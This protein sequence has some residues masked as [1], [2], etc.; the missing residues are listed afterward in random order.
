MVSPGLT[1]PYASAGANTQE[2]S[3]TSG[4]A[5]LYLYENRSEKRLYVGV[6]DRLDRVWEPHNSDAEVLR[7]AP[8]SQILQT[9]EPFTSWEDA[10]KAEAVAIHVA[11][12]SGIAVFHA[13]DGLSLEDGQVK[14]T[15]RAGTVSTSVL[16]PAVKR[17]EGTVEYRDLRR[18][19]IVTIVAKDMND[20]PGPYGGLGGA[21]FSDRA[22]KWWKVA[23]EK[24]S[25][26][27]RLIA[28]L[29]ASRGVILG[30]WDVDASLSYGPDDNVFPF[31]DPTSDDPRGI[32]GM[33]LSGVRGQSGR[34]YS[35]D[36]RR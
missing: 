25:E 16:G 36:L 8:G 27:K 21:V 20:R 4:S 23:A 5:W 33:R 6:G 31:V 10:R 19:A 11:L 17:R 34:I 28:I 2:V 14:L 24:Q 32:K 3:I 30:D 1:A 13:Q 15:N 7:D 22:R 9:V 26:V 18:T 29:S 35:E 12:L